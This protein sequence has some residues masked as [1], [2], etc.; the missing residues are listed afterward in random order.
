MLLIPAAISDTFELH[1]TLVIPAAITL[2]TPPFRV[3]Q[4]P[5]K[6]D[7]ATEFTLIQ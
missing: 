6:I 5:A 4:T 7:E 1:I 2:S 3:L